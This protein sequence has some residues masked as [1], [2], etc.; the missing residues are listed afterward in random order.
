MGVY[1]LGKA[2][3]VGLVGAL[4]LFAVLGARGEKRC[5]RVGMNLALVLPGRRRCLHVHHWMVG[6]ALGSLILLV[7][8]ASGGRPTPPL[9]GA[10]GACVGAVASGF[11]YEDALEIIQPCAVA[12]PC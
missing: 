5:P 9:S 7:A 3:L 8:R 2:F 10:L 4:L 12:Q 1:V 6:A 11:T